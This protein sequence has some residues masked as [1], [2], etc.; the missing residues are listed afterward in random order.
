MIHRIR[1]ETPMP[2]MKAV[3]AKSITSQLVSETSERGIAV[4]GTLM[5]ALNNLKTYLSNCVNSEYVDMKKG[6]NREIDTI[7]YEKK[8]DYNIAL[9]ATEELID[10]AKKTGSIVRKGKNVSSK[11]YDFALK[12]KNTPNGVA[13][14]VNQ[15]LQAM[16]D[17]TD[18]NPECLDH[19]GM[20]T[21]TQR[22]NTCEF[23]KTNGPKDFEKAAGNIGGMIT[24]QEWIKQNQEILLDKD[25]HPDDKKEAYA[26]ILAGRQ[27]GEA[28]YGQDS[29]SKTR[30]PAGVFLQRKHEILNDP[31]FKFF[32]AQHSFNMEFD[33]A[34]E[35]LKR[36]ATGNGKEADLDVHKMISIRQSRNEEISDK[37]MG[38]Y[39]D[40]TYADYTRNHKIDFFDPGRRPNMESLFGSDDQETHA[41]KMMAA[42]TL[43]HTDPKGLVD[44]ARIERK[45]NALSQ[46][47][48]FTILRANPRFLNKA[49]T[50][51]INAVMDKISQ[52]KQDFADIDERAED[53]N[54]AKLQEVY[55]KLTRKGKVKNPDKYVKSRSKEFQ[56]MV[57]SIGDLLHKGKEGEKISGE[58]RMKVVSDIIKYQ[59][60]KER[61]R[62]L[63]GGRERFNLS[64]E[65]GIT[66]CAGQKTAKYFSD[67]VNH[68]NEI[69][70]ATMGSKDYVNEI[71]ISRAVVNAQTEL[72][73]DSPARAALRLGSNNAPEKDPLMDD[74]NILIADEAGGFSI[75]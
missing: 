15:F 71:N 55:D 8:D 9:M 23:N 25:V 63:P 40:E 29:L 1:K 43:A 51:N 12:E 30:I 5:Y 49:N 68:V 7:P 52:M 58:D 74:H 67:Q 36:A 14:K 45:A 42:A 66:L 54:L 48:E 75:N 17:L 10:Y 62:T 21:F 3:D 18:E 20:D 31:S 27:L 59:D 50:G 4:K 69:R 73:Q 13:E 46:S 37:L 19:A 39:R 32:A 22:W 33:D 61:R 28:R 53:V 2:D 65:A 44:M 11:D 57:K 60:G 35:M 16:K 70:N 24:P 47:P 34:H 6:S 64:M 26:A 56:T 41:A 38:Y 72:P